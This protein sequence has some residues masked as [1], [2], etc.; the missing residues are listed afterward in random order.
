MVDPVAA[1]GS[2]LAHL[3]ATADFE[4]GLV[5]DSSELRRLEQPAPVDAEL[6][7]SEPVAN[8]ASAE[9]PFDLAVLA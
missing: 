4:A 7:Q 8:F 6:Q 2:D 9:V 3:G 1:V 5:A